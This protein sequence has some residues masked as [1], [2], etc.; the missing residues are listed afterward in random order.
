M[1]IKVLQ[2]V[3][4]QKVT[5]KTVYVCDSC[6]KEF[7]DKY[8][9]EAHNSVDH[10]IPAIKRKQTFSHLFYFL[11][12]EEAAEAILR[13]GT[14]EELEERE[15]SEHIYGDDSLYTYDAGSGWYYLSYNNY[16]NITE[17]KLVSLKD[18][19]NNSI[20]RIS[21]WQKAQKSLEELINEIV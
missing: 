1:A 17:R 6:G 19:L 12:D 14:K 13:Y 10:L 18:A 20:F 9:L 21:Y 4:P 7:D 5:E 8:E 2:K 15:G 16:G 3:V 11:P